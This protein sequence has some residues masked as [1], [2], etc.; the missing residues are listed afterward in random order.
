MLATRAEGCS[1]AVRGDCMHRVQHCSGKRETRLIFWHRWTQ[2]LPTSGIARCSCSPMLQLYD[3]IY[4][5]NCDG[6]LGRLMPV[7]ART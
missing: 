4:C 6:H 7:R 5:T 1:V 2:A 3:V